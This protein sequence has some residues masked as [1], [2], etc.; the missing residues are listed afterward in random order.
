MNE[1]YRDNSREALNFYSKAL[2]SGGC[3]NCGHCP[4]NAELYRLR[5]QGL[6]MDRHP[7]LRRA[8]HQRLMR[9]GADIVEIDDFGREIGSKFTSLIPSSAGT[10]STYINNVSSIAENAP[11]ITTGI[12][13]SVLAIK[14][15]YDAYKKTQNTPS[16][17]PSQKH[18]VE[19]E[20]KKEI[21]KEGNK[22]VKQ[23]AKQEKAIR[24]PRAP[25]A[26]A[27]KKKSMC[28]RG[29]KPKLIKYSRCVYK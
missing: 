28:A 7:V 4:I 11:V 9:G 22:V 16:L 15:L 24:A 5:G 12:I 25:R 20:I 2:S 6:M 26:P 10:V 3:M 21:T 27:K 19:E 13:S 29:Q 23:V 8:R 14:G 18:Q 1:L 17:D